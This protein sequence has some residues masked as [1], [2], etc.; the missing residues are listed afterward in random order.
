MTAETSVLYDH[1]GPKAKARNR[2]FSVVFAVLLAL[3]LWWV[4]ATL[5]SK[6]ELTAAKWKPF[7]TADVWS[8]FLWLGLWGTIKAAVLSVVIALPIGAIFAVG[9]LSDHTWLR[10]PCAVVVEFFRAI[11]VLLLMFFALQFYINF[12]DVPS[13]TRPLYAVVTGLV[14]YNGSVLAEIFRSGIQSLPKGQTE[15]SMAIG[16]RKTQMMTAILLPQA[17]TAMLPAVVSQLV[18][19]LKDTALGGVLLGYTDLMRQ[20]NT[21]TANF[22]N[23][24]ATYTVIAVLYISMNFILSLLARRM[25]RWLRRRRGQKPAAIEPE[26][27]APG[28]PTGAAV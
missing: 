20:A 25:E 28:L 5:N 18:V 21:L 1:P 4:L 11:P 22:S 2:I 17:L 3:L 16:L 23:S 7:T 14:L 9:R 27:L 19:V 24:V 13:E 26:T 8:N 12:T 10:W 6:Q 15:A